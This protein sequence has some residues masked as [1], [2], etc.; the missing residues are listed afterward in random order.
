MVHFPVMK[1]GGAS[2]ADGAAVRRVCAVVA[3]RADQRPAVVVSAH[4]G[5][6]ALLEC[7]ARAAAAGKGRGDE[8]RVRHHTL[9]SQLGLDPELLD[10]HL[11]ELASILDELRG[12]GRV[13]EEELDFVLSFGE[14][15]SSRIVAACLRAGG[16]AATPVDAFDLG[17]TS[18][19]ALGAVPH[20]LAFH[21]AARSV[22]QSV[23]G[24]PVVTGFLAQDG[25]GNLTTLGPNGSDLTAAL[26]AEALGAG[27]VQ[28]WKTV[29]GVMSADPSL[30]P[31]AHLI[32]A[33]SFSVAAEL[34][35]QGAEVLHPRALEPARRAGLPV[36]VLDVNQPAAGGTLIEERDEPERGDAAVAVASEPALA[37]L[38]RPGASQALAGLFARM[39]SERVAPRFTVAE[40][41][42]LTVFAPAG[43]GIERVASGVRGASIKRQVASVSVVGHGG[44]VLGAR[45]L[46][47]LSGDGIEVERAFL[48]SG[49]VQAFLIDPA[50]RVAAVRALHAGLLEVA[51]A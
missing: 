51:L 46:E 26:L 16:V 49:L 10:R 6:T 5:V 1:F 38:F 23:P 45:A 27:E 33:M 17:L 11:W 19:G 9:L 30:V 2:L 47:L 7:E 21:S 8:V 29:P 14:R 4:A 39:D 12:R 50:Q 15:M 25:A 40:G 48:G 41:G 24:I 44:A 22:L 20:Q 32:E 13:R 31:E 3:Q 36:R 34:A 37:A 18:D 35:G 28:L 43:E 42:G